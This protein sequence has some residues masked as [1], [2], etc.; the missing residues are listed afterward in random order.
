VKVKYS[1]IS[2]LNS[3]S[4]GPLSASSSANLLASSSAYLFASS[5]LANSSSSISSSSSSSSESLGFT[6]SSSSLGSSIITFARSYIGYRYFIDT[7]KRA[8]S[9]QDRYQMM[10]VLFTKPGYYLV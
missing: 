3:S 4:E 2:S 1:E 7:S 8:S 5:Y 9:G 10:V 6:S